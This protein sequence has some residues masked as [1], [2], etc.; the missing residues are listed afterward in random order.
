[1][2][3]KFHMPT[4]LY[5]GKGCLVENYK[6]LKIGQKAMIVTGKSGARKSGALKDIEKYLKETGVEYCLFDRVV[7]NPHL[8]N[9]EEGARF[10]MREKADFIIAIGGGSPMDAAKAIAALAVNDMKA[11][12]LIGGSLKNK[13]LP[14]IAVPTTSGTGSEVTPYSILTVPGQQTKM[15]FY[16]SGSFPVMAFADPGYT[17]SMPRNVTVDTAFD[18]FTHLLESY[19]SQRGTPF[20]DALALEGIE[21]WSECIAAIKEGG[22][23]YEIREKL[24]Y[25]STVGG[26]AITNTGTTII[27]A[28]GYSLTYFKGIPHGRAN[29]MLIGEYLKYNYDSCKNKIDRVLE[30]TGF[31]NIG[32]A[33]EFFLSGTGEKPIL[34]DREC[35]EYAKLAA[36][37]GSVKSNPRCTDE[38]A[39][40]K[41]FKSVFGGML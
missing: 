10:C 28:M 37:Q 29:A 21:A 7:N 40:Y 23:D 36:K 25:A 19:L 12:E 6:K 18:A 5:F 11:E 32:K 17:M 34:E 35:R 16:N 8:E 26:I 39:M 14:T 4:E 20:N 1:M 27:H 41:M 9:V 3:F 24:M 13:P 31:E 22:M 38:E 30:T 33:A 2:D 15:N